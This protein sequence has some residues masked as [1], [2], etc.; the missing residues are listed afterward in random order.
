MVPKNFRNNIRVVNPKIGLERREELL[1]EIHKGNGFLPKGVH[2]MDMDQ[3]FIEFVKNDLS[4]SIDGEVVPS[5]FLTIQRY[6]E[7]TKT[8]SFVDEYRNIKMPFIT[9]VRKPDAQPG[10]N[11]AGL[12][13]IPGRQLWTYYKVP[14]NDG[15]RVGVD[16]YQIPQ[17]TS[18]DMEYE[19]RFFT[20][21]MTDI[22]LLNEKVQI[23]FRSRQFYIYPNKHP[24]PLTLEGLSDE[25]NINDFEG[26]R[27]YV[28]VYTIKLAGYILDEKDFKIVPSINR[29]MNVTE[30]E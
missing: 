17:P 4:I 28:Q 26:R 11:Y 24:M 30:I 25:S 22:N 10:T 21:K 2:I 7:F 13:N 15:S 16:L 8:W 14:T 5:I 29:I 19:V 12:Y 27:F 6:S 18:V 20:N 9:I 23:A 1:S 3:S